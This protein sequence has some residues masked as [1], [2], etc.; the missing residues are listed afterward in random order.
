MT[1]QQLH[2]EE[3]SYEQKMKKE[4]TL[5]IKHVIFCDC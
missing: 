4:D 5:N 2:K 3:K 1:M